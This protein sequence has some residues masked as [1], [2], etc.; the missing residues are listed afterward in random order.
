MPLSNMKK[1][2]NG[3]SVVSSQNKQKVKG[4]LAETNGLMQRQWLKITSVA[5]QDVNVEHL[6]LCEK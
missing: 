6:E 4:I 1:L 5:C 3:V 2:S